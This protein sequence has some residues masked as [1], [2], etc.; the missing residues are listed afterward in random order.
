[1]SVSHEQLT[2]QVQRVAEA[3]RAEGEVKAALVEKQTQFAIENDD[4]VAALM[5]KKMDREQAE[6]A[7]KALVIA[8][9]EATGEKKPVPGVEVKE[10]VNLIYDD[11]EAL[12]WAR[13]TKMA[14]LPESLDVKAFEKI[15]KATKIPFIVEIVE[16]QA[17]IASDLE[18]ALGVVA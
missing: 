10:K 13:S 9:F 17:Q 18:K 14:L 15:A 1:M 16:P 4:L 2:E 8:H 3:R 7:C 11:A 12:E 6:A 5:H